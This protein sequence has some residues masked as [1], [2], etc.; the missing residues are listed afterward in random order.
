MPGARVAAARTPDCSGTGH[1]RR[2]R[3][4]T[5]DAAPCFVRRRSWA[6]SN[7]LNVARC[8]HGSGSRHGLRSQSRLRE[9]GTRRSGRNADARPTVAGAGPLSGDPGARS[10]MRAATSRDADEE[11]RLDYDPFRPSSTT[12][13]ARARKRRPQKHGSNAHRSSWDCG[14]GARRHIRR[15]PHVRERADYKQAPRRFDGR[16]R[17]RGDYAKR[18]AT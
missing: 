9:R 6:R 10:W 7:E 16:A 8:P 1:L 3:R 13:E 5:G 11:S 14:L 2:R 15:P 17:P 18:R 4:A 12:P